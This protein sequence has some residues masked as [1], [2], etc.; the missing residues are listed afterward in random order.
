MALNLK[1]APLYPLTGSKYGFR[2]IQK[3]AIE[4][5]QVGKKFWVELNLGKVKIFG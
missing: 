2:G 1:E 5:F 3:F 4:V